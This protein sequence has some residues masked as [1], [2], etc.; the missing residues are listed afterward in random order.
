[1]HSRTFIFHGGNTSGSIWHVLITI[2]PS[3]AATVYREQQIQWLWGCE[4]P[5]ACLAF[6]AAALAVSAAY[7]A[8]SAAY[9]AAPE[10]A[11][12]AVPARL[13]QTA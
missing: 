2:K 3:S 8:V 7:W 12:F 5:R 11:S 13:S 4:G 9:C 10:A 6:S 1:M